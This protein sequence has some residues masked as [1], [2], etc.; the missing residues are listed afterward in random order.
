[1]P[2]IIPQL[3]HRLIPAHDEYFPTCSMSLN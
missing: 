1:L 3:F 2:E